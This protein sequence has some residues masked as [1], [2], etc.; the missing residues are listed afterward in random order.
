MRRSRY[1]R[2]LVVGV[3]GLGLATDTQH[4]APQ[5]APAASRQVFRAGANF[6][7]VDAYPTR[8]GKI[9][10]NLT[11]DD[12]QV[13]EDG[14]RQSIEQFEFVRGVPDGPDAVPTPTRLEAAGRLAGDPR[15]RVF[16][17]YLTGYH[18]SREGAVNTQKA[19][20]A[21]FDQSVN[22]SDLFGVLRMYE[23]VRDLVLGDRP[24]VL[25]D[26]ANGYWD[27]AALPHPKG[28]PRLAA[29]EPAFNCIM[30]MKA[31]TP[32]DIERIADQWRAK[33]IL[34][35]LEELVVRLASM[36]EAR[37]N[38]LVFT[39]ALPLPMHLTDNL[40]Q[41]TPSSSRTAAP[42]AT[43]CENE[44]NGIAPPYLSSKVD[45]ILTTA[46]RG[47]V[48]ISFI[49]PAG[50]A[51]FDDD[52]STPDARAKTSHQS[53]APYD[54]LKTVALMTGGT[55]IVGA[56]E[57]GPALVK[58]AEG[59]SGHYELGYYSSNNKFDGK[60]RSIDVKVKTPGV[61]VL[62]RKGYQAPT[63]AMFKASQEAAARATQ[64]PPAPTAVQQALAELLRV[65]PEANIYSAAARY[66]DRVM[67][68]AEI[69]SAQI[70]LGRW[71]DGADVEVQLNAPGRTPAGAG[72]EQIARGSR[73][74]LVE[75]PLEVKSG[76]WT[77]SIRVK[78]GDRE[79]VDRIDVPS[80][81][82]TLL[83]DPLVSR[84]S[85]LPNSTSTP[86]ADF[87]FR[88]TERIHVVWPVV[89]SLALDRRQARLLDSRGQPLPVNAGAT[90]LQFRPGI[91]VLAA[92]IA[93]TPLA[94]G[95]YVVEMVAGAGAVSETKLVAF[96]VVR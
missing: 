86:V 64:P 54:G 19:T 27:W 39:G 36:R 25:S 67:V 92:D 18:A 62:A 51:I 70:E 95:D 47:N 71:P 33:R 15:R 12:F 73:A 3:L 37:S 84:A 17:V 14:K 23:D 43:P 6:V 8:D 48:S 75:V 40:R 52:I 77:A 80:V 35:S 2:V 49:D 83:G 93:L 42:P 59:Q 68:V 85:T 44:L 94:P 31:K 28:W 89:T 1:R 74:A 22:P 78:S 21:F 24:D 58:I 4:A 20:T 76:P 53:V 34:G 69:A 61:S 50:L 56:T 72:H 46:Q 9:V 41:G 26:A 79:L 96:R 11:R 57:I 7:A 16:V 10:D 45:N 82:G 87:A 5:D 13:F 32:D 88:R 81:V 90:E 63:A 66:G 30:S 29:E 38:V 55:A 91:T 65:N 60:Y